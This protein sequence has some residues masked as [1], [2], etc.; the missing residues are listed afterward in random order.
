MYTLSWSASRAICAIPGER[1][2]TF[3]RHG[4]LNG[5]GS[6]LETVAWR[7]GAGQTVAVGLSRFAHLVCDDP[8]VLGSLPRLPAALQG[9]QL[10][11]VIRPPQ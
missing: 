9:R 8:W 4:V 5:V 10:C 11:A 2:E 3:R 6:V 1:L 7:L